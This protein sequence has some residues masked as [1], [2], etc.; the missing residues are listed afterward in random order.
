MLSMDDDT[1]YQD[2]CFALLLLIESYE[3]EDE[4]E[5]IG[6]FR[7]LIAVGRLIGRDASRASDW[8]DKAMAST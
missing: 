1:I 6:M 8:P 4:V 5:L 2:D 7:R 3:M